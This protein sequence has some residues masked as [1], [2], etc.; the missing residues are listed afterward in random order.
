MF[1]R[2]TKLRVPAEHIDGAIEDFRADTA[3]R[4]RELDGN[5]GSVMLVDREGGVASIVTYWRDEAALRTSDEAANGLRSRAASVSH[6]TV[7][8]VDRA[9]IV[10]MERVAEP[11]EGTFARSTDISG[12]PA[13]IDDGIRFLREKVLPVAQ[14]QKGFRAL[15]CA[16]NRETGRSVTNSIWDTLEDLRA[17]ESTIAPLREEAA[18]SMGANRVEVRIY[19]AAHIDLEVPARV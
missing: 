4:L 9:E 5:L 15:I 12:D 17:N 16:V 6:G 3:K 10:L 2:A 18:R 1:I 14:Q 11:K 13:K 7:E 19:Q 8:E